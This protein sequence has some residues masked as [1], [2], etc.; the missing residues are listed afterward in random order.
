[1]TGVV[2]I[3]AHASDAGAGL[4]A[5]WLAAGIGSQAVRIV[6]PETLSLALWSQHVDMYGRAAT[7]VAWPAQEPIEDSQVGAV[8]NRIRTCPCRDFA[9]P[10]RTGT[11]QRRV[12]GPWSPVACGFGE[13]RCAYGGTLC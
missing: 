8:L 3:L 10:P 4:V 2:L 13:Q 1:M 9:G 5:E 12:P 7:R 11:T 6:R